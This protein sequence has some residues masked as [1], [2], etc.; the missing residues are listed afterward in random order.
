MLE[1]D[2]K[3]VSPGVVG[4]AKLDEEDEMAKVAKRI[5]ELE[6]NFMI[7]ELEGEEIKT[8][9]SGKKRMDTMKVGKENENV[10]LRKKDETLYWLRDRTRLDE[11]AKQ[12]GSQA[13]FNSVRQRRPPRP[14]CT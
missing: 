8:S 10:N 6:G 5:E 12:S 13:Y 1:E 9:T 11:N 3:L 7:E 2:V 14:L 4:A